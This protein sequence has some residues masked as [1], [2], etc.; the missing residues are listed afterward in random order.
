[1]IHSRDGP[2]EEKRM[3]SKGFLAG[4]LLGAPGFSGTTAY[5][6]GVAANLSTQSPMW[7]GSRYP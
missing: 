1:M 4:L 6:A 5:A 7:T 2:K 3:K